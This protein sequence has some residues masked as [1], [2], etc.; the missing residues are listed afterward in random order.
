MLKLHELAPSPNNTKVRMA[1][2]FKG[3]PFEAVA[4]TPLDRGALVALSGQEMTPVIEDRGIVLPDSEAIL[5]YLDANY[6]DLPRLFPGEKRLRRACEQWKTELDERVARF[7]APIFFR[8]LG[9]DVDAD[10][11]APARFAE[12]MHRLE[13]RLEGED[14]VFGPDRPICDLRVAEWATY[15][16]PGGGLLQRVPLFAKLRDAFGLDAEAFPNLVRFLAP[17]N[18][19]LA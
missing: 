3:V 8:A 1:L 7:W 17:W 15:A 5:H 19:R 16:F 14:H 11:D 12:A 18:E 13:D 4:I 10:P 6:R 9:R 2:R